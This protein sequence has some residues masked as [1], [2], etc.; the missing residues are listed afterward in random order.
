MTSND[1]D[2]P[3]ALRAFEAAEANV[4]RLENLWVEIEKEFPTGNVFQPASPEYENRCR[5]YAAILDALPSI[6]GWKPTETPL[7]LSEVNYQTIGAR[8]VGDVES[9]MVLHDHLSAPG[10]ELREYRFRLDQQRRRLVRGIVE[11]HVARI[12]DAILRLQQTIPPDPMGS[13]AV[14]DPEFEDVRTSVEAIET[15]LGSSIK[16]PNRWSD[17]RRHLGFGQ[18]RDL[19]DIVKFDWPVVRDGLQ[20]GLYAPDEPIPVGVSDLATLARSR[21]RG[22]VPT[23]L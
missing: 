2:L 13:E 19:V 14:I 23:R 6:D 11:D 18:M 3:D 4:V 16:R 20:K 22:K 9:E 8:E 10:R 21:P 7:S 15:L 1:Q 17:L 12:D 5:S